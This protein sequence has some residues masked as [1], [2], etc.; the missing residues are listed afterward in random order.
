M[1]ATPTARPATLD[2]D[3]TDA[4]LLAAAAGGDPQGPAGRALGIL[5]ARY[6][7]LVY[8]VPV[9]LGLSASDADDVFQN[10]FLALARHA[11]RIEAAVALPRWLTQTARRECWAVARARARHRGSSPEAIESLDPALP[12]PAAL[13][14]AERR[15]AVETALGRLGGRCEHLLRALFLSGSVPDYTAVAAAVGMPV[16]SIGPT[17][18]RCLAKLLE[19]LPAAI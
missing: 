17:R 6:R 18:A 3:T 14:R 11:G 7:R 4:D 1:G 9:R 16:G 12:V 15:H 13:E 2:H 8:S 19:L 5:V 10:T